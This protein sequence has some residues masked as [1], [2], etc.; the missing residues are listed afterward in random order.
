MG[1]M[2]VNIFAEGVCNCKIPFYIYKPGEKPRDGTQVGKIVKLWRGI[3]TEIGTDADS[4]KVEFP[5]GSDAAS[6]AR[7]LGTTMFINM[8]F[9]EKGDNGGGGGA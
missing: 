7:L 5:E 6:R 8:L 4:F 1:G 3:M 2:C 9:F